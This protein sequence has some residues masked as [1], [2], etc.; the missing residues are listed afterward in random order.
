MGV[1]CCMSPSRMHTE[2][3]RSTLK[4]AASASQV[5]MKPVVNE[6]IDQQALLLKLQKELAETRETL[7]NLQSFVH[8]STRSFP[9]PSE[10]AAEDSV[11]DA[12]CAAKPGGEPSKIRSTTPFD[13]VTVSTAP[14]SCVQAEPSVAYSAD[15]NE[16][17]ASSVNG[18]SAIAIAEEEEMVDTADL[19]D[20][21][22]I[23]ELLP[24][25][26]EHEPGAPMNEVVVRL[27][28]RLSK[29]VGATSRLVDSEQRVRFLEEKLGVTDDLVDKLFEDLENMRGENDNLL[30]MNAVLEKRLREF[31]E[32]AMAKEGDAR[33]TTNA[34]TEDNRDAA[35]LAL[36]RCTFYTALAMYVAGQAELQFVTMF[37][38]WLTMEANGNN[39]RRK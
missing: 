39:R 1:L 20:D 26:L 16:T 6:V 38:M 18:A 7:V 33:D 17:P 37:F 35:R 25:S 12:N 15:K 14:T 3:T 28:S 24:D 27:Q 34:D 22:P 32:A 36:V 29:D 4:F 10:F 30:A 31:E 21:D 11:C 5:I 2:E 13:I 19:E 9:P 23:P 8:V